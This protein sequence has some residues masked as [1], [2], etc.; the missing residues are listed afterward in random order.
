MLPAAGRG[1]NRSSAPRFA[2]EG[3]AGFD[4][5]DVAYELQPLPLSV[6]GVIAGRR[7]RGKDESA[8]RFAIN[9]LSGT[10]RFTTGRAPKDRYVIET[11]TGTIG[12]RDRNITP[13]S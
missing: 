3:V 12:V 10:F 13:V 8:G 2:L 1:S 11:P 5:R 9:A 7:R 6:H 4:D